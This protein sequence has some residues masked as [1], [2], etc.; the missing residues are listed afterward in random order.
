MGFSICVFE[1]YLHSYS[2]VTQFIIDPFFENADELLNER[3]LFSEQN[4]L[5][6]AF[7]IKTGLIGLKDELE[8]TKTCYCFLF[9]SIS[10]LDHL[11]WGESPV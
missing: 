10:K 5:L 6:N 1:V 8:G 2:L 7:L 3:F 11:L 4:Y 9:D